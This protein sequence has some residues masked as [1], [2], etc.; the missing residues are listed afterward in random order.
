MVRREDWNTSRWKVDKVVITCIQH[1]PPSRSSPAK[2]DHLVE[3]GV[4]R[5]EDSY[6]WHFVPERKWIGCKPLDTREMTEAI[7]TA[8]SRLMQLLKTRRGVNPECPHRTLTIRRNEA[9]TKT[10]NKPPGDAGSE[11]TIKDHGE[12]DPCENGLVCLVT[13]ENCFTRVGVCVARFMG[14]CLACKRETRPSQP[15]AAE[16][17]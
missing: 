2:G 4:T 5:T 7:Q 9:T 12:E 13:L 8:Y 11:I 1:A 10:M 14:S 17:C 16:S 6:Q 15:S 3:E